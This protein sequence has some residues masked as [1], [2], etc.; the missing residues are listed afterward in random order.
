VVTLI[1]YFKEVDTNQSIMNDT[2]YYDNKEDGNET[3]HYRPAESLA[4]GYHTVKELLERMIIVSGNNSNLLLISHLGQE[5]IARVYEDL[6]IPL[7]VSTAEFDFLS[8][9]DYSYLFRALY[10]AT[11]LSRTSSEKAL[12]LL[13]RAEFA[14]GLRPGVP[15]DVHI[16][17]KFGERTMN[18][19][20]LGE[21]EGFIRELHDC[22]I[23]YNPQNPYFLCI[24]TQGKEFENL[25]PVIQD[26]SKATYDAVVANP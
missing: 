14:N 20:A 2:I 21:S 8:T 26:I 1:A 10:N 3:E 5:K 12:E 22:G 17:H 7:P 18:T 23:I 19:S 16:A 24:M 25:E 9:Q 15:E 6:D 13:A 11:Y 4:P